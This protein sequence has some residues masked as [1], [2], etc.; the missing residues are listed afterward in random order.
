MLTMARNTIEMQYKFDNYGETTNVALFKQVA[1]ANIYLF[2]VNNRNTGKRR[3]ICSLK[4]IKAPERR[5]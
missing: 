3:E 1:L 4:T 5:L 2:E